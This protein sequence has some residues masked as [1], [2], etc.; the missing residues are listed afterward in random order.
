MV[1]STGKGLY[2]RDSELRDALPKRGVQ[3]VRDHKRLITHRPS[4]GFQSYFV[5]IHL[6]NL[7]SPDISPPTKQL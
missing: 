1:F 5:S 7:D 3:F 6:R 2:E 4:G